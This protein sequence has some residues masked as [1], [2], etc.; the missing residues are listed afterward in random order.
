MRET[1]TI[2][3][4]EVVS[5][6]ADDGTVF[7]NKRDCQEHEW[8]LAVNRA[9]TLV[10]NLRRFIYTPAWVD[11]DITWKWFLVHNKDELHAVYYATLNAESSAWDYEPNAYPAWVAC[12]SDQYG[13]GGIAGDA[14]SILDMIQAAGREIELEIAARSEV[15]GGQN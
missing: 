13:Y 11:E 7:Q 5:Y 6:K 15:G 9:K 2:V 4:S 14:N 8:N 3:Q 12:Y 1:R 10:G